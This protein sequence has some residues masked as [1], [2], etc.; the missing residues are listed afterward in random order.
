[1]DDGIECGGSVFI[2]RVKGWGGQSRER[3][4]LNLNLNLKEN[5]I[6]RSFRRK[7]W[8]EGARHV[9]IQLPTEARKNLSLPKAGIVAPSTI[10]FD[11]HHQ[12]KMAV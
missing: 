11:L 4:L 8:Q 5:A 9:E 7:S 3:L 6:P 12:N 1:M 2:L 10:P